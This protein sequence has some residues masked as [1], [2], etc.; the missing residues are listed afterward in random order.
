VTRAP[1]VRFE[2][3][4]GAAARITLDNATRHNA[5][6]PTLLDDLR[7][8]LSHVRESDARLLVLAGEGRS[9]STGGDIAGFLA[10]ADDPGRLRDYAER[11]VQALNDAILDL[12][13]FPIPIIARVQGATT[14]GAI[15]LVLASDIVLATPD[16]FFQ[17]WYGVVGFAPD[18]GW[19]ALMGDRI[20]ASRS[21]A[22]Q[23]LNRRIDAGE[24]LRLGLA[25]EIVAP[26]E[27]DA[28]VAELAETIATQG[29]G[30]LSATRALVWDAARLR[31]VE[32]RLDAE[33]Q[34]FVA[35]V[36]LPEVIAAMRDFVDMRGR[37][38]G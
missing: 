20:G 14:G 16:A 38:A 24:A 22:A 12:L 30:T 21:I 35:R 9:F 6:T 7:A 26:D 33:K 29:A 17:P 36:A 32:E 15:G 11:I 10:H 27:R 37:K 28:R 13:R 3:G 34:A 31:A 8:A 23:A 4:D 25:D 5:L 19:T 18:G 1:L 2:R